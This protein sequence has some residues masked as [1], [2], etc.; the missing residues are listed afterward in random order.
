MQTECLVSG[1]LV[2]K[3]D[4]SVRFLQLIDCVEQ[5]SAPAAC[6]T[7]EREVAAAMTLQEIVD[8]PA[9]ITFAFEPRLEGVVTVHATASG[10]HLFR[11]T[12]Q[13]EN[14]T[15][16][17][18]DQDIDQALFRSLIST[19]TLLRVQAG[20]FISLLDPPQSCREFATSCQNIGTWPVLVGP[21]PNKMMLSAPII[22]YDYPQVATESPG[23]LFDSTEIDEVLSL[24]ILTLTDAEKQ[25]MKAAGV[26]AQTVLHRTEGLTE[27]DLLQLH[28]RWDVAPLARCAFQP[29]DRVRL[30]PR[31]GADAL[32][33]LLSGQEAT[34]VA[35]ERD[36]ENQVHLG[37][38]IDDDPGRDFGIQ[39]LP[40]HR[41]FYRL[42]E[43]EPL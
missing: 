12:V 32:D 27:D 22:L 23:N 20:D 40:G 39:G 2:T 37:V 4:V 42:E 13:I 5:P 21:E 26:H 41:F 3:L 38:V 9:Q 19:H 34:I 33:T 18:A 30:R 7:L 29:G 17:G 28:G 10:S 35:V 43:V 15:P 36:F 8:R 31:R 16:V 24:R 14:L 11:L 6:N 1:S 25:E